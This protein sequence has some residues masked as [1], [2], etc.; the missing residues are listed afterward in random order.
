MN[1]N[2]NLQALI[3]LSDFILVQFRRYDYDKVEENNCSERI[4]SE[5]VKLG[6][7]QSFDLCIKVKGI[8]EQ[9]P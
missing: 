6:L 4:E 7:R 9:K 2:L 1:D 5:S 3:S 8:F